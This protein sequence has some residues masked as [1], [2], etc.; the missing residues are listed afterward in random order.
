M[1]HIDYTET[2]YLHVVPYD[3][4]CPL[5]HEQAAIKAMNLHNIVC[6]EPMA[7]F[8]QWQGRLALSYAG[9]TYQQYS[10]AEHFDKH[11]MHNHFRCKD[12]VK[13]PNNPNG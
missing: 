10:Y 7:S 2:S 13:N 3:F 11:A 9:F 1:R 8:D 12:V 6:D 5:A 4:V